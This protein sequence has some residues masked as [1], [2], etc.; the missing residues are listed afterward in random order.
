MPKP[1]LT[2]TLNPAIDGA[3]EADTVRH[4]HK[5]RTSNERYDPGGGGIN[6]ARVLHRLGNAVR[7]CYLSGGVTGALLDNLME[8]EGID[9]LPIP[10]A[11]VTRI[12]HA[13]Y[14]RSSGKEYRFVPEGPH[15]EEAEWHGVIDAMAAADCEILIASGSLPPG[16]PDDFYKRLL[17]VT[18]G[19]GVRMILDSSGVALT[20]AV[21]A[22]GLWMIKPSLG[23]FE[24]L[25][26]H[27]CP[28]ADTVG[29]AA[30]CLAERGA[31]ELIVV[32]MGHKGAVFADRN[33]H[34]HRVPPDVPVK[35]ATGAGDSFVAGM[36]HT[37]AAGWEP[38]RA[39]LYGMAAGTAAVL[40]P[41][42]DLCMPEDVERLFRFMEAG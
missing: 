26:G 14:E 33:G 42:T 37:L 29:E 20:H 16:I 4:T 28:D 39:F 23:E 21:E 31:A 1:I 2:L 27:D 38:R 34:E 19:K 40:T 18:R 3:S 12:S 9:R 36:T 41:G 7:A 6:V 35:S 30:R 22:G 13:V 11:D 15:V 25:V 24:A 17:D 32:T 5:I 8:R 10:I